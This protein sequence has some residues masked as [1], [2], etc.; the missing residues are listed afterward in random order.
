MSIEED[1]IKKVKAKVDKLI[2][3]ND[4]LNDSFKEELEKEIIEKIPSK[5]ITYIPDETELK[6]LIA[7]ATIQLNK[8]I[9]EKEERHHRDSPLSIDS[10]AKRDTTDIFGRIYDYVGSVFHKAMVNLGLKDKTAAELFEEVGNHA[11]KIYNKENDKPKNN[12]NKEGRSSDRITSQT[13]TAGS[14]KQGN[15]INR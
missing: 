5:N 15:R 8:E 13:F 7:K 2:G 9:L 3:I 10:P 1:I 14:Q 6:R 12:I 4:V 11:K